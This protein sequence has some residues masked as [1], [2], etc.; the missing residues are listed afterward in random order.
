[1]ICCLF[2]SYKSQVSKLRGLLESVPLILS[3]LEEPKDWAVLHSTLSKLYKYRDLSVSGAFPL[4]LDL[5]DNLFY[6]L[7]RV[8]DIF[9][10]TCLQAKSIGQDLIKYYES[11]E[12]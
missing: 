8:R 11:S 4:P 9:E 1:M 10:G 3:S 2:R 12:L 6:T 5:E 7:G